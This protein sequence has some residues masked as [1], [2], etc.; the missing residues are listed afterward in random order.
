MLGVTLALVVSVATP[1]VGARSP[2]LSISDGAGV[3]G[4]SGLSAAPSSASLPTSP[5]PGTLHVA[6]FAPG[7]APTVDPAVCYY[8]VCEEPIMNVYQTLVSYN[9]SSTYTFVPTAAT[10]VPGTSQCTADYGSGVG[11]LP[12]FTG[13]FNATGAPF[14]GTNGVPIYWTFVLDPTAHFYDPTTGKGWPVYPTDVMFSISRTAAFADL[15]LAETAGWIQT[16]ALT[17]AGNPRWD[18]GMHAPFNN[19]PYDVLTS[20]LVN[21]STYCPA[22]AMNGVE[23]NGCITFVANGGGE[24]WPQFLQLLADN[25]G[26]SIEPCGWFTNA[27]AGVPGFAG[28]HATGGDGSCPLPGGGNTTDSGNAAYQAYLASV[29]NNTPGEYSWDALE[30]LSAVN[31]PCDQ[32]AVCATM[33]GSGPYWG[34]V[35]LTSGYSLRANPAYRQPSACGGDPTGF[36]QYAGYCDPAPGA[37]IANASV[38]WTS[39]YDAIVSGFNAGTLDFGSFELWAAGPIMTLQAAGKLQLVQAP[40]L[41]EFSQNY[42][43]LWNNTTRTAHGLPGVNNVPADFFSYEAARGLMQTAYPFASVQ[44]RAWTVDGLP[45]LLPSGGPI[46]QGMGCYYA[47]TI[48]NGCANNYTVPW[49]YEANGGVPSTNASDPGTAGWWWAQG[50]NASSPYYD[51]ELAACSPSTPCQF[52][53]TGATG[54]AA[55]DLANQLWASSIQTIT[56]GAIEPNTPDVSANDLLLYGALAAPGE[57]AFP[58]YNSGWVSDFPDP[59]DTVAAYGLPNGTFAPADS[60]PQQLLL[61]S[62]DNATACGHAGDTLANL[63]YWANVSN[64]TAL[65]TVCQG[66]AYG[67]YVWAMD[68]ASGLPVPGE[69]LVL[70]DLGQTILNALDLYTWSGQTVSYSAAAPWIAPTSVNTNG[71]LGAGGDQFWFQLRYVSSVTTVPTTFSESG[72]AKGVRW[73]VT[74]ANGPSVTSSKPSTVLRLP[75]GTY[76]Y[77]LASGAPNY[78]PSVLTGTLVVRSSPGTVPV[79][80]RAT[81]QTVT[82]RATGL[83]KGTAW[84]VAIDGLTLSG[85]SS[86]QGVLLPPGTYRYTA[87][88]AGYVPLVGTVT[89]PSTRAV[90][91]KLSFAPYHGYG[92]TFD[93][94]GLPAGAKWSVTLKLEKGTGP[95]AP[96]PGTQKSTG[97][98]IGWTDLANGTYT[99]QAKAPGYLTVSGTFQISGASAAPVALKFTG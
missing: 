16:Q 32:P 42:V 29:A 96:K 25:L 12:G 84:T 61:P 59:S 53:I 15:P 5:H 27:G 46:P 38:T 56:G 91:V 94:S 13:I 70:F 35:S 54:E 82:F 11:G 50:T 58:V 60:V 39:N 99:F 17:P 72:L 20:M 23:G 65:P 93:E 48:T 28:T 47:P 4:S 57:G 66:V 14:T 78:D 97:A 34:S 77:T 88:A 81:G 79:T 74:V 41:E 37:Y 89:V 30:N 75:V 36:A 62:F 68:L 95:L 49:P 21:N 51:P 87:T 69:R 6:E 67:V 22:R 43:T 26:A 98:S 19:T 71:M 92:V 40:S 7:G 3:A 31:Y 9:G 10:C 44:Q 76:E 24:D 55:Q 2:A 63:T 86:S 83:V 45:A 52:S 90:A 18:G 64:S 1:L 33:L 8:T 80:F 85:A 73:T